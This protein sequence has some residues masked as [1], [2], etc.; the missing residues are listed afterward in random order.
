[1]A[2]GRNM[3]RELGASCRE[4]LVGALKHRIEEL[5]TEEEDKKKELQHVRKA[6]KRCGHPNW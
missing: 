3:G 6:L 2:V 1:M 5:V 4:L